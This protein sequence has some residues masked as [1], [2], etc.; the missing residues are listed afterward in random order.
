M[1][2]FTKLEKSIS[3]NLRAKLSLAEDIED[4]VEVF[5]AAITGFIN[6]AV[7]GIQVSS[8]DLLFDPESPDRFKI[9]D[10]LLHLPEFAE[11]WNNSDLRAITNRL[12]QSCHK[13]YIHLERHPEKTK[14][15]IRMSG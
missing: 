2:S 1:R 11:V 13:R 15:K 12:A 4:L 8:T 5:Y 3:S 6:E 7:P 9:E 10:R 14:A